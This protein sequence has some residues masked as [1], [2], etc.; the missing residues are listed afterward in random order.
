VRARS[1]GCWFLVLLPRLAA[2]QT[3]VDAERFK[4]A[5]THDG[6]VD[7]EGSA[8][9][10]T[11][12]PWEF[13][14]FLNYARNPLVVLNGAGDVSRHLV[15]GHA[16]L[17]L[18]ASVTLAKPFAVGL[19]VPLYLFQSG[20]YDPSFGGL[21][22]LRLVPK[23]RILDDRESVGLAFAAELR[24]PTHTGDYNGGARNVTFIPKAI[25]DH[26]FPSGVHI[27]FN[28]GAV[29]R[30]KTT[31]FNVSAGS[32][33]AYAGALGYR[34]GGYE[35]KT[36]LGLELDG[37]VGFTQADTEELPLEGFL[38]IR[39][40][41]DE[42]WEIIGGPGIGMIAGYG[43][44]TFR[45]FAG[46]RYTPTAHDADGDG[47]AD[48]EDQCPQVPEDHDGDTDYDGC[49]EEDPDDDHDG[50]PNK[51]D[52]C[53]SAKETIN[54]VQDDDG[55]PDTGD[56]RV[57][58]ENGKIQVLDNVQ[59]EHGSAE[60]KAESNSLLDQVALHMK[61]NPEIKRVRVEGH[62]DDTGP[63]DVNV[64]LSK[65]RAE[66]VRQHLVKKG[67]NPQRLTAEG[68]GPDRPLVKDTTE[69]ARAKNRRVEFVVEQ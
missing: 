32:E 8:V 30:E 61:A 56:P 20:D 44:P 12:D 47:I 28:L 52:E 46:I 53:P 6:W 13:G 14:A 39:H 59:F 31:L 66:A 27:G 5:V 60:I 69:E 43:V 62:T 38:F 42:E 19:D 35:G 55:C 36:E 63:R 26:R 34:V 3:D 41:P 54:G 10:P 50:V 23:I 48:D 49:P 22:D 24:V 4:P 40:N 65:Q 68:Y 17:D 25:L 16:G 29:V 58:Y 1:F 51:S 11:A 67:V 7:A 57:I 45:I 9:R 21:G 18:F 33:L 15:S 64:R 37:G 2:A